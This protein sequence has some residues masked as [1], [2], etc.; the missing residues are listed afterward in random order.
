MRFIDDGSAYQVGRILIE[1]GNRYDG[2]NA[3]DWSAL[4]VH[5]AAVSRFEADPEQLDMHVSAGSQMVAGFINPLKG[6]YP[7][8]DPLQPQGETQALLLLSF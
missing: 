6:D 5:R 8:I 4:R 1:H 3:N 7:F 2:A